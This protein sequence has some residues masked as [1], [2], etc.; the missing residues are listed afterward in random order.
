MNTTNPVNGAKKRDALLPAYHSNRDFFVADMMDFSLKSDTASMEVPIFSLATKPDLSTYKWES[1]DGTRNLFVI[2]STLG[3]ATQMDKD[4]L[5]YLI[6]Q[7]VEGKNRDRADADHRRIRFTAYDYLVNT[8]KTT[9]GS[10][11]KR[12]EMSL[13]RLKGTM[14]KTNIKTDKKTIKKTFGLIDEWSAI[15]RSS[16]DDRT[17]AI[18]VVLSEWLYNSLQALEV[19]TLNRSYFRLRKP[20]E[21]RLYELARKHCGNQ[22]KWKISILLLQEKTGSKA[23][24]KEFKRM[25][26]EI[27]EGNNHFPEYVLSIDG[28]SVI[29]YLRDPKKIF[30]AFLSTKT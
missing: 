12:L 26:R 1:K 22:A 13:D 21:R 5:I 16:T 19:L 2:P 28:E 11:Y 30:E 25:L 15:E 27:A 6:S 23:S 20:L 24:P 8:N 4:V 29:F 3:R 7:I 14:L 17:I 18:E 10:N 9:S